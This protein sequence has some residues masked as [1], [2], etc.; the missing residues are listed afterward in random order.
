MDKKMNCYFLT[1]VLLLV[2]AKICRGKKNFCL[3]DLQLGP[4]SWLNL[5]QGQTRIGVFVFDW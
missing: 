4:E 5:L 3:N 1:L 2:S